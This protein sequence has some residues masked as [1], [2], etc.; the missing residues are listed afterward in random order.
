VELINPAAAMYRWLHS[1]NI[2]VDG[3]RLVLSFPDAKTKARAE[4]VIAREMQSL[5]QFS[6]QYDLADLRQFKL[7]GLDMRLESRADR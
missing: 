2:P 4:M 3:F 1:N 5:M 7:H 6:T